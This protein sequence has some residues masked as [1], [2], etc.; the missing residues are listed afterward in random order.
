MRTL[1]TGGAG[2]IGSALAEECSRRGQ[3]V[4]VLDDLS[5]GRR[6]NLDGLIHGSHCTLVE[7]SACDAALV[8]G[9]V[10]ASDQV[11]HLAASV[12]MRRVLER[13]VE[14]L[15]NNVR[16]SETVLRAAAR[17]RVRILLASSSEVYGR[18]SRLPFCE[19][20]PL[21]LGATTEP[22]WSY[23][24][25]KAL[26]EWLAF[27]HARSSALDVV[28]VRLF[29]IA[30]ARQRAEFG[31]VL[32][33]LAEQALRG[34]ALTVYGDGA[35]TRCFLHVDDAAR[36][37]ADLLAHDG[38]KG[39]VFNVGSD[40]E[41]SILTLAERVRAAAES[42]APIVRMPYREAYGTGYQ[43]VP[44]RVPELARLRGLLRF[45]PRFSLDAI[46]ESALEGAR[47]RCMLRSGR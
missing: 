35:Q 18:S 3:E 12:G 29:N 7:G 11:V 41:V 1:I 24:C 37:I 47:E 5:T 40:E 45:R 33:S 20:D 36:T 25:S 10:A 44:R 46:V 43:D 6:E 8:A 2:F 22:R 13:P 30:G 19:D 26:G 14:T 4:V 28:V 34:E 31:M 32:P 27:A 23:A 9:L 39:R 15:E 17:A 21:L 38:A 42:R 16:G